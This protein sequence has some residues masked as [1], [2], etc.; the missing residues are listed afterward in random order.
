MQ[1][2]QHQLHAQG[3]SMQSLSGSGAHSL[4]SMGHLSNRGGSNSFEETQ[5]SDTS[6]ELGH[7]EF[8]Q[9]P[10]DGKRFEPLCN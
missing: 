10:G 1:N 3:H 6:E 9:S 4:T 7:F 5:L 2:H 8:A